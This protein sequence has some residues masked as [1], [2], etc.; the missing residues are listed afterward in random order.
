MRSPAGLPGPLT[1]LRRDPLA[2]AALAMIGVLASAVSGIHEGAITRVAGVVD[3]HWR[4]AYDILVRPAGTRL[5]L[6]RTNGLVE[7]NFV[8]FSGQ[9]GISL[10]QLAAIR[11]LT[12]VALAAPIGFVG[13]LQARAPVVSVE[14]DHLPPKPTLFRLTLTTTTTD[15][16]STL[17]VQ[18][19]T[20]ELLIGP[21]A[22]DG[23]PTAHWTS[24]MGDI[25]AG[26]DPDGSW[27]VTVIA[28][29]PLPSLAPPIIAVDPVAEQ[30]L[31]ADAG[32]FLAPLAAIS[33]GQRSVRSFDI[34]AIDPGW[35]FAAG[36]ISDIR[37][38]DWH[39]P[40][41]LDLPV[42]PLVVSSRQAATL[43]THLEVD[44][45]GRALE[46]YPADASFGSIES[47][48]G[49]GETRIGSTASDVTAA[50]APLQ[51]PR[52]C[53]LWPGS[54]H[55][56]DTS[57]VE[58]PS[59][60]DGRLMQRPTYE[61]PAAS[62]PD[63]GAPAFQIEQV[64]RVDP[65]GDPAAT[66]QGAEGD[67]QTSVFPAFRRMVS[68]PLAISSN[69]FTPHSRVR[70]PYVL[71]PIGTFD[72]TSVAVPHDPL[73]AVPLGAYDPNDTTYIADAG[74]RPVSPVTMS[75]PLVPNGLVT[76][77]PLA[78]TDMAGARTLR[79]DQPIDAIR[80][81]VAG[82]TDFGPEAQQKVEAVAAE[83]AK[84]GLDTDIVAGSSPQDVDIYVPEYELA[85]DPPTD[86]GWVREHWTTIGAAQRVARGFEDSDFALVILALAAAF[87]WSASLA[88]LRV[89]RRGH[90]AAMLKA[91]GWSRERVFVWLVAD[92]GIG[93]ILVMIV[94]AAGH[95]LSGAS[96]WLLV[97]GIAMAFAWLMAGGAGAV[98]A[99]RQGRP[100]GYGDP[101]GRPRIAIAWPVG[102]PVGYVVRSAMGRLPWVVLTSS[103]LAAGFAALVLAGVE[104]GT[105]AAR[106]GP[107]LLASATA[108]AA[109]VYQPLMLVAIAVGSIVFVLASLGLERS[110]RAS[111]LVVLSVSGWSTGDI[112]RVRWFGSVIVGAVGAILASAAVLAIGP[113]LGLGDPTLPA[114]AAAALALAATIG[115]EAI[116][117]GPAAKSV[118]IR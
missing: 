76:P 44:Q 37:A 59:G 62:G 5:D 25:A 97:V 72:A 69:T 118:A 98:A 57:S 101:V 63:A 107:T 73:D 33:P 77:P 82:V 43:Q 102:G 39:W 9:G 20:G 46:S 85:V 1:R 21:P 32:R 7:P 106:I 109:A 47:L 8:G 115:S 78:I 87:G 103:G 40:S 50:L 51:D 93:S 3:A 16:L 23:D 100:V 14:I 81:R 35:P 48:V 110:R 70:Q 27:V 29:Q 42:I 2:V 13:F 105:T 60:L 86:L 66:G 54:T 64:G 55:A 41:D 80:V 89:E 84:L 30:T 12:G 68:I 26:Q 34:T 28:K 65:N 56:C 116:D 104:I 18:T 90:D 79:G 91:I 108:T 111:D 83:I 75:Y 49:P 95:V 112:D 113:L 6:E 99:I 71:E 53:V 61:L 15:G 45:V 31:L 4:G 114:M 24:S 38:P 96:G 67:A 10:D 74:G 94:G 19:E 52:M 58:N 22:T 88:V 11:G 36:P 17:P 92:A 117:R